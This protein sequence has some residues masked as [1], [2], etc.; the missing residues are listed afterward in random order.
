MV[1]R[2]RFESLDDLL[3]EN[4]HANTLLVYNYK[5]ELEELKRRYPHAQTINDYKAIER[6]N[7]GKICNAYISGTTLCE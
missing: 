3:S 4:Q 7:D 5:E 1:L 6:W 2:S